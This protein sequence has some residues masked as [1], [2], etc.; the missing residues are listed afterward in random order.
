MA[1]K[2]D[3]AGEVLASRKNELSVVAQDRNWR[4][5]VANELRCADQWAADWGFLGANSDAQ[6]P[7]EI[8]KEEKI[9]AL[10]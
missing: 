8:T 2:N 9:A 7:M 3:K 4:S 1:Q 6:K 10:E 5:Y